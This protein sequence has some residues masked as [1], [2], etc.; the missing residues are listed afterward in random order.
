[1]ERKEV[2]KGERDGREEKKREGERES[3]KEERA[4]D[5]GL[6]VRHNV[7]GGLRAVGGV[8]AGG[9]GARGDG[10]HVGKE[11]LGAVEADD[12]HSAVRGKACAVG[13]QY[14]EEP[15]RNGIEEERE[16]EEERRKRMK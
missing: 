2:E 6:R 15:R 3:G 1:M 12:G 14:E 8:D 11:P 13:R 4:A 9:L 16:R 5:L 10:A 7:C